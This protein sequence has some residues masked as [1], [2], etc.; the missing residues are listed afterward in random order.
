MTFAL[1]FPQNPK[2]NLIMSF[3]TQ[4]PPIF[5]NPFVLYSVQFV[6][7]IATTTSGFLPNKDYS[8]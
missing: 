3:L 5:L 8:C 4:F 1:F 7:N 6:A 2:Q